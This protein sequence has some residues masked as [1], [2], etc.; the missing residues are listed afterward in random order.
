MPREPLYRLAADALL[1]IH[2]VFVLFVAGS[3][4]LILVG[5]VR[6]WA[7][8]R[9]IWF[10]MAHLA[11]IAF[12]VLQTWLGRLCPL[13]IWEMHLRERAGDATYHGSFIAHWLGE[14]LYFDAPWWVFISAY[15][16]FA[17]LVV[18]SW[19]WVRPVSPGRANQ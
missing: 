6:K 17:L 19:F 15:T 18:A 9:N 4:V 10:R 7:W 5:K 11:A 12:V 16:T 13:T 14:L 3:L 8:V 1:G 2:V